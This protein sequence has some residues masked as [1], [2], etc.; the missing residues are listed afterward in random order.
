MFVKI[1]FMHSFD[2][3]KKYDRKKFFSW[4]KARNVN[5]LLIKN[6]LARAITTKLRN[7]KTSRAEFRHGLKQ[8]GRFLA[9]KLSNFVEFPNTRIET[10]LTKTK[11]L[12]ISEEI[13][14]I[15]I[16]RAGLPL[17][18]GFSDS[19]MG[20]ETTIISCWRKKDLK[21]KVEYC[22]SPL[23][24]DKTVIILDPMLA[25]GNTIVAVKQALKKYGK[26][27]QWIVCS[28]IATPYGIKKI[29]ENYPKGLIIAT[30]YLDDKEYQK[31]FLGKGLNSHGYIV[32]G[33]GDAGDRI[34]GIPATE[35]TGDK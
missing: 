16:L 11:G 12:K 5:F 10:P 3:G 13:V 28:V 20:V 35:K 24:K 22:K 33:L 18:E 23:L 34:F 32:P 2:T 14:I 9:F 6:N 25:T 1:I 4:L 21:V 7:K 27:K 8:L 19:F 17:A 15:P 26:P 31:K 29:V 30:I